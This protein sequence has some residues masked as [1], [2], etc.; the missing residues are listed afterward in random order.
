MFSV[1]LI[2]SEA[3]FWKAV[4]ISPTYSIAWVG[5][6]MLLDDIEREDEAQ[7]VFDKVEGLA[8][9]ALNS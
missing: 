6:A 3:T 9:G 8:Y 1:D 2:S 4:E 7:E 5:L